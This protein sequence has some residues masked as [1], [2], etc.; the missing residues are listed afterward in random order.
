MDCWTQFVS[1]AYA[2]LRQ[3]DSLRDIETGLDA[4]LA[5][6]T[7]L[8]IQPVK[9]STLSDANANRDSRIYEEAFHFLL[10]KCQELHQDQ[11]RLGFDNPISSMDATTINLCHSLFPWARYRKRKGAIKMHLMLNHDNGLPG[12]VHITEGKDHEST[13]KR[14]FPIQPDSIIVF[15]RG[16]Y[17]FAWFYELHQQHTTFVVRAKSN[18]DYTLIG[19]H[20]LSQD[21]DASGVLSDSDIQVSAR[22]DSKPDT[23]HLY[24]MPLRLVTYEDPDTGKELRFLTNNE[25]FKPETIALIYKQRWKI[26]LFFKWIKQHLKIKT[27]LGTSKN[28]VMTQ[29]WVALIVY[30]ILWFVKKQ[31]SYK[32]SLHTLSRVL[33]EAIF[34]RIHLIDILRLNHWKPPASLGYTQLSLGVG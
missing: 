14:L 20:A 5:K 1:L 7:H 29:I 23:P 13:T 6:L 22:R 11:K 26:E 24:P 18:L 8:G 12:F 16:Y 3:R 28:A 4:Q 30:L 9:R 2:Q 27:F 34:E 21:F 31:T 19:Q 15:D 33:N 25:V 17:D 10:G 32:N